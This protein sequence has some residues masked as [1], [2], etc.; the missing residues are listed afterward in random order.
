MVGY[1]AESLLAACFE[2]GITMHSTF[3]GLAAYCGN[4]LLHPDDAMRRRAEAWFEKA[5]DLSARIEATATG[6][7]VGALCVPDWRDEQRCAFLEASLNE[8]LSRLAVRA[9]RASLTGFYVEAMTVEREPSPLDQMEGLCDPGDADHAAIQ[10][11]LDVGHQCVFGRDAD[12]RDPYTWLRRLGSK[13]LVVHLQ[14]SDETGN[15]HWPFTSERNAE[16]RIEAEAVLAALD[17][18]GAENAYLLLEMIHPFE[19][20]D[21][22]VLSD[23][24]ASVEYWEDAL[25]THGSVRQGW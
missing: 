24:K 7:H 5:I 16:G 20:P 19:T 8:S 18:S 11:C 25:R 6:G 2:Y 12:E 21:D 10:L 3:T 17:A 9:T 13:S 14:Q 4:L 23:L 22:S 15:H 1:Q